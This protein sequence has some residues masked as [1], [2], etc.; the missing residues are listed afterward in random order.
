MAKKPTKASNDGV[1]KTMQVF[2]VCVIY[3]VFSFFV[4]FFTKKLQVHYEDVSPIN[5]MMCHCFGGV[6]ISLVLIIAQE[7]LQKEIPVLKQMGIVVPRLQTI[8][9]HRWLGLQTGIIGL[10]PVTFG[11]FCWQ[12]TNIPLYLAYRRCG[13]LSSVIVMYF[14][15]GDKPSMG[16]SLSTALVTVGAL[17]AAGENVDANIQGFVRVWAY[18][19]SQS[20][21]NVYLNKLNKDKIMV[22][23]EFNFFYACIGFVASVIYNFVITDDYTQLTNH[24]EDPNFRIM[25]LVLSTMQALF[26]FSIAITVALAGPLALNIT[27]IIKDVFL[28]YAGF[29]FFDDVQPTWPVLIG[30]ALSFAGA[31]KCIDA[32][33]KDQKVKE[34]A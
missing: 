28:T 3:G 27:G 15:A 17:T 21:Q 4:S 10:I 1:S 2:I 31:V 22:P 13:L 6:V 26:S 8:Y 9:D 25:L 33:M 20:F 23:F 19:F 7:T 34:L 5:V 12:C 11:A 16:V 18:N 30:L 14:W 29:I 32:K 24:F